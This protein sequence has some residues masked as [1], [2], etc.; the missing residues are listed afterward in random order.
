M[1]GEVGLAIA[2]LQ[3]DSTAALAPEDRPRPGMRLGRYRLIEP[4][5]R[6]GQGEVWRA[7]Q[8]EPIVE[9]VA[10]KL[11]TAEHAEKPGLRLQFHRE[12]MWGARLVSPWLLPTYEF[13]SEAGFLYLAQPLIDGDSLAALIACRRRSAVDGFSSLRRHWLLRLPRSTY[14]RAIVTI[15]ARVARALAVA[16]AAHV[17]HRDIKPANILVDRMSPSGVYLCDFG[18][19]RDLDDPAPAPLCDSTGTPL[20]MAPERLLGHSSDEVLCDIYALGVTL[21]EAATLVA[22]F[23]YPE[24]Q[25]RCVWPKYLAYSTP[26]LPCEVAPWLP[27]VLQSI[28]RR[29]MSR[30]PRKR[31]PS[32]TAVAED[33]ERSLRPAPVVVAAR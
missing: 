1:F 15:A 10:L 13:G 25:P 33:L 18:L 32:M 19:G 31:Y 26:R 3:G 27:M 16:H 30:S 21:S 22:P 20:Y 17:V 4:L 6:G 29:A 7:L 12:A 23:S 2:V 28:I 11:L 5:G 8:V 9:E 24:D 14:V